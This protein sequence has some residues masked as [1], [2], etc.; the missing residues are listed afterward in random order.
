MAF[1]HDGQKFQEGVSGNPKGRPKGTIDVAVMCQKLLE[2]P[3]ELPDKLSKAIKKRFGGNRRAAEALILALI[4]SGLTGDTKAI[5]EVF[6]RAYG[7]V[8]DDVNLNHSTDPEA[9]PTFTLKISN[10]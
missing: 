2:N 4:E 10:T 7:K 6:D 3:D 1:P 5:K 9:P 8:T